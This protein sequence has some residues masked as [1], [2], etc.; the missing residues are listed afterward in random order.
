[1]VKS[2]PP[3][4]QLMNDSDDVDVDD[5]Y[6][7]DSD[8]GG[9]TKARS[10]KAK[11]KPKLDKIDRG[12]DTEG[13]VDRFCFQHSKE[14]MGPSRPSGYYA[15]KNGEWVVFAGK[16]LIYHCHLRCLFTRFGLSDYIPEYLQLETQLA[17]RVEMEKVRSQSD[18]PG[19]IYTF[20]IRGEQQLLL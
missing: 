16:L 5:F 6:E 8:D 2:G 9:K 3:L 20:E 14:M 15:R 18:V 11:G 10:G 4:V 17:L 13:P 19:Y 1:M 7:S 12:S